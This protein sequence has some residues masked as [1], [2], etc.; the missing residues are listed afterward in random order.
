MSFQS[1]LY[2]ALDVD[3]C[4]VRLHEPLMVIVQNP[5]LYVRDLVT[6][7]CFEALSRLDKVRDWRKKEAPVQFCNLVWFIVCFYINT[8]PKKVF[9]GMWDR[10]LPKNWF[11]YSSLYILVAFLS[12][13]GWSFY[14]QPFSNIDT[15]L[16][17]IDYVCVLLQMVKV[18]TLREVS[19]NDLFPTADMVTAMSREFGVP[20]TAEDFGGK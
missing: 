3:L 11:D 4:R 7:P 15:T 9:Q 19:R 17:I 1:R 14:L 16:A 20:L 6:K 10:T 5:L 12:W 18:K 8:V 13:F 2:S